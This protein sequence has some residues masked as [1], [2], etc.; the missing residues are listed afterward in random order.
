MPFLNISKKNQAFCQKKKNE[1]SGMMNFFLTKRFMC[2]KKNKIK[3]SRHDC[4]SWSSRAYDFGDESSFLFFCGWRCIHCSHVHVASTWAF[5]GGL[6]AV[7]FW[8]Y[9]DFGKV[10]SRSPFM[11]CLFLFGPFGLCFKVDW[12]VEIAMARQLVAPTHPWLVRF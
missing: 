3:G 10:A 5:C 4:P 12:K 11:W 9:L 6:V 8:T 1:A 7:P 2:S